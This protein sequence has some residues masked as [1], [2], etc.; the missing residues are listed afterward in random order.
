M[1]LVCHYRP[2]GITPWQYALSML[3]LTCTL[4]T[5]VFVADARGEVA[6]PAGGRVATAVG[7]FFRPLTSPS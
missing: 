3:L 5:P 1:N 6:E 7:G 2:Q 4:F